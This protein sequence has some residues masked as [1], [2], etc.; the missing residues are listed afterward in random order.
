[1][2][3][4]IIFCKV[5]ILKIKLEKNDEKKSCLIRPHYEVVID[6]IKTNFCIKSCFW[7]YMCIINLYKIVYMSGSF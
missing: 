3:H 6:I 5:G 7:K 2:I 4:N 1:M